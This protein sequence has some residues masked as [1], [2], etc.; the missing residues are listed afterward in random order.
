MIEELRTA[1]LLEGYRGAPPRDMAAFAELVATL[2]AVAFAERDL[3]QEIE[4][5]PVIVHDRGRGC[6]VADALLTLVAR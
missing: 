5:N 2:S 4:L 1:P 6:T 3:I